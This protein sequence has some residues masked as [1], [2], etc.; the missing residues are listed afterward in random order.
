[1]VGTRFPPNRKLINSGNR[2]WVLSCKCSELRIACLKFEILNAIDESYFFLIQL[3]KTITFLF[4]ILSYWLGI[5]T[6]KHSDRTKS[7][8][9]AIYYF[10][11]TFF[12]SSKNWS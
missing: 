4:N 3:N 10:T 1:M 8:L 6:L 2:T 11:S 9:K 5:I 7:R 12:G